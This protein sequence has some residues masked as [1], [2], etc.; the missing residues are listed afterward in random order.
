M[1]EIR[2]FDI[3]IE[4]F[5]DEMFG[6]SISFSE[7]PVRLEKVIMPPEV[8]KKSAAPIRRYAV[9]LDDFLS[10]EAIRRF[11]RRLKRI[12]EPWEAARTMLWQFNCRVVHTRKV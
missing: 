7:T 9:A 4:E 5:F 2:T 11:D 3:D 8:F 10:P 12:G 1:K 6:E